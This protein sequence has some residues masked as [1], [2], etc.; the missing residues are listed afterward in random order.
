[1]A[2]EDVCEEE[3]PVLA[4]IVDK[5]VID[6]EAQ[7]ET[8]PDPKNTPRANPGKSEGIKVPDAKGEEEPTAPVPGVA[9]K[10]SSGVGVG[11]SVGAAGREGQGDMQP[12]KVTVGLE[13]GEGAPLLLLLA[14]E[15]GVPSS[16]LRGVG[17]A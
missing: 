13:G 15:L 17:V 1:M 6:T 8:L 14:Q 7:P 4:V 16:K 2:S 10:N 11:S 3:L 5:V 9:V 12:L